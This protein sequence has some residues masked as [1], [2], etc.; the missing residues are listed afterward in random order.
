MPAARRSSRRIPVALACAGAACQPVG[1]RACGDACQ[2]AQV[3]QKL[4]DAGIAPTMQRRT[5]GAM[6]LCAPVH[7][8]AE[9]VVRAAQTQ[10]L[11]VSRATV[12]NT[13]RLFTE[14]G[15][16]RELPIE[17][18]EAVYDSTTTPHHHF[19]DLTTGE[20]SDIDDAVLQVAGL[21]D[22]ATHWNIDTVEVIVRGRRKLPAAVRVA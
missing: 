4:A 10:A 8:T 17:G 18:V 20:V 5:L 16:L 7:V 2:C 9:Q 6:L 21:G 13:L 1:L 14:H 19:Y 15:L 12:Y 3:A 11:P 22:L